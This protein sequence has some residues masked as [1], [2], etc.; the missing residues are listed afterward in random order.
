MKTLLVNLFVFWVLSSSYS[1]TK[2]FNL[3]YGVEINQTRFRQY[4]PLVNVPFSNPHNP[5]YGI[6]TNFKLNFKI[7][8]GFS[9]NL[10]PLIGFYNT[11]SDVTDDYQLNVFGFRFSA[12][13]KS[14]KLSIE[15]GMEYN[16]ISSIIGT[17]KSGK[18]FDWTFFAHRRNLWGPTISL[19]YFIN[20][21]LSLNLRSTYFLKDFFSSGALDNNGDVVGPVE[22]TPFVL[23]V[24]V[25]Y[26]ITDGLSIKREKKKKL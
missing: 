19:N 15:S 24:G 17:F 1:Q 2:I 21:P 23:A 5:G 22:V 14:K 20:K 12:S 4:A 6:S 26:S 10:S 25:N 7:K 16:R 11:F 18:K 8:K 13:C 3:E 9:L